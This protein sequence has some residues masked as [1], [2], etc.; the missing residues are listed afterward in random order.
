MNSFLQGLMGRS[1]P[2][3]LKVIDMARNSW[4]MEFEHPASCGLYVFCPWASPEMTVRMPTGEVLG[5]IK[6][7]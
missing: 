2:F 7:S 1:R 3:Y 4:I 6:H 5:H